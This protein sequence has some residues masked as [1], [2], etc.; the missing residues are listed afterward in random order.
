VV[1]S[2]A[3]SQR[4]FSARAEKNLKLNI[5]MQHNAGKQS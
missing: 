2:P 3:D 4:I 5:L 1:V